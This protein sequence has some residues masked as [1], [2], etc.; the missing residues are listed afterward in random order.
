MYRRTQQ[1]VTRASPAKSPCKPS[2]SNSDNW[3]YFVIGLIA[4]LLILLILWNT[5]EPFRNVFKSRSASGLKDLEVMFFM[6]P[7]CPWC[8][9]MKAGMEK[10]GTLRDVETVDVTTPEGQELAKKFG[11]L[12]KGVP[13]FVSKKLRTGTVGFKESTKDLIDALRKAKDEPEPKEPVTSD[14]ARAKIGE[15]R[16]LLFT[17]PTCGWCKK[18]K[19]GL[20]EAGVL[21]AVEVVDITTPEGKQVVQKEVPEFRGVPV[22]KSMVTG[23]IVT[24]YRPVE[25]LVAELM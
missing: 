21:D 16:V 6:S 1:P 17:S 5:C 3:M 9:K 22:A 25:A 19:E 24:G 23:K 15:L 14:E 10:D 13:S 11:S 20:Q 8:Q 18:A 2:R 12:D 7:K 4:I